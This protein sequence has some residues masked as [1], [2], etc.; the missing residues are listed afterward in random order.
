MPPLT[1]ANQTPDTDPAHFGGAFAPTP[2]PGAYAVWVVKDF[3]ALGEGV[4]YVNLHGHLMERAERAGLTPW[5][6]RIYDQTRYRPLVCLGYPSRR[7]YLN[8][9][10]SYLVVLRKP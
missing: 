3:R 4:P 1:A 6:V 10:H 8:I 2:Y 5:D 9:G 7:F